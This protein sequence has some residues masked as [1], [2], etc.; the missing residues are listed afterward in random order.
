MKFF[1]DENLGIQLAR[2]LKAFGEDTFHLL[3]YFE[4]GTLDEVWLKHVG[5][6]GWILITVDKRIRRRP[7]EKDALLRYK[8]GTFFLGGKTVSRWDRIKQIVRA[9]NK[10]NEIAGK[11]T[12]PF[13][14]QV[15]LHGTEFIKL[16]LR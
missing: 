13:A 9:W 3:D 4:A 11:E 14:Y 15:N 16:P 7:L 10:I 6:Q 8:V 1:F 12:P 5:E 2:G